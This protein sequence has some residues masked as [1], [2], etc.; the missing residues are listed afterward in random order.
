MLTGG[1]QTSSKRERLKQLKKDMY[2]IG[3][4]RPKIIQLV[5]N[6]QND[7]TNLQRFRTARQKAVSSQTIIHQRRVQRGLSDPTEVL[8]RLLTVREVSKRLYES[9]EEMATCPC[10]SINLQLDVIRNAPGQNSVPTTKFLLIL[11]K[12]GSNACGSCD[13]TSIVIGTE[14]MVSSS[15]TL[16]STT[17]I[18]VHNHTGHSKTPPKKRVRWSDQAIENS[19]S[20]NIRAEEGCLAPATI[21]VNFKKR[22]REFELE[23]PDGKRFKIS[24]EVLDAMTASE[25]ET[26]SVVTATEDISSTSQST[27]EVEELCSLVD[28]FGG[29][30]IESDRFLL[31]KR[32]NTALDDEYCIYREQLERFRSTRHSLD[33]LIT[34]KQRHLTLSERLQI[35]LTL[36]ISLLYF[37]SYSKSRSFFQESWRS[38]DIYFFDRPGPASPA[39]AE[40]TDPFI[41]YVVPRFNPENSKD[42]CAE[43][44]LLFSLSVVMIETAMGRPLFEVAPRFNKGEPGSAFGEFLTAR[45]LIDEGVLMKEVGAT[46]SGIVNRCIRCDFDGSLR[47]FDLKQKEMQASD[48]SSGIVSRVLLMV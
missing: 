47:P 46:F 3:S 24:K 37:G 17:S 9:L 42:S 10:H 34:S 21:T 14:A 45:N 48:K 5:Q 18:I 43:N 35:C 38:N 19:A 26:N 36:S 11:N 1:S 2:W 16:T 39:S 20:K 30:S 4:E 41:P 13:C 23:T 29:Q 28:K 25:D 7:V 31:A 40:E 6:L 15:A 32:R 8:S 44:E 22:S 12:G 33:T 27:L